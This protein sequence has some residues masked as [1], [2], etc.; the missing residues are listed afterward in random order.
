MFISEFGKKL[1]EE[2]TLAYIKE[3]GIYI[4]EKNAVKILAKMA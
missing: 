1:S 4:C 2:H 3:H